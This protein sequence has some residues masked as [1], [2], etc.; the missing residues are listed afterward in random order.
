MPSESHSF[1]RL[2]L[3]LQLSAPDRAMRFAAELAKL[4][5]L[6]LLGLFLEDSGLREFAGIPFARELRPLGGGWRSLDVDQLTHD[7]EISIRGVERSFAQAVKDLARRSQFEV[8]RGPVREVLGSMSGTGDIVMIVEPASAAARV[9]AQFAGLIEAAFRSTAAVLLVPPRIVRTKGP[10]VA[11]A[12]AAG[13][14]SIMAAAAIAVAAKETLVVIEAGKQVRGKVETSR[15]ATDTGLTVQRIVGGE[16]SPDPH[17][18][19]EVMRALQ[20][21]LVVMARTP[22][23]GAIASAIGAAR[24]VPVLV[25]EPERLRSGEGAPGP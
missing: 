9:S 24:Q 12:T 7:L 25:I 6:D 15:L 8:T 1:K 14:P 19:L 2:V 3:G 20:E 10:I 5:D 23:D 22:F 13:D 16:L 17:A 11:I 4:L 21:R 18:C